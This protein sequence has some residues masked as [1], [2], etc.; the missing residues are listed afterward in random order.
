MKAKIKLIPFSQWRIKPMVDGRF[1]VSAWQIRGWRVWRII[2]GSS[3]G[4]S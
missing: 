4:A 1:L 3:N 2:G